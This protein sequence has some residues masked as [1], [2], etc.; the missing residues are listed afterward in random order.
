[1]TDPFLAFEHNP[2]TEESEK[3]L[4]AGFDWEELERRLET[5]PDPKE[6]IAQARAE[7]NMEMLSKIVAICAE[8]VMDIKQKSK[9]TEG[10]GLRLL[11]AAAALHPGQALEKS[12]SQL[13]KVTGIGIRRIQI[14]LKEITPKING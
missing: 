4:A 3:I 11:C 9:R 1:M 12:T 10:V 2:D 8:G 7:G 5:D 14:V 6:V 13:S